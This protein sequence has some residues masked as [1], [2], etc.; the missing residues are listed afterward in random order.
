MQVL[1]SL[2]PPISP[3]MTARQSLDDFCQPCTILPPLRE[4]CRRQQAHQRIR[5]MHLHN[6]LQTN[7]HVGSR[8]RS[9]RGRLPPSNMRASMRQSRTRDR[10]KRELMYLRAYSHVLEQDLSKLEREHQDKEEGS[11]TEELS[12]GSWRALALLRKGER[13]RSELENTKLRALWN[14]QL[15]FVAKVKE[16]GTFS[17]HHAAPPNK[18]QL[19]VAMNDS[20]TLK[21]MYP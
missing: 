18:A 8:S 19:P 6:T 17:S 10:E 20:V 1:S 4:H 5:E 14:L 11:V 7:D 9:K 21:T 12:N 16:T 13:E 15:E 2:L 3:P